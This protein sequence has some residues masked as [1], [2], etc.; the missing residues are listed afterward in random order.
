MQEEIIN[1]KNEAVAQIMSA[2][3]V[4]ELEN[5]KISYLGRNGKI[6]ALVQKLK[7]APIDERK[8]IGITLNQAKQN[9]YFSYNST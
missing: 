4:A 1:L 9:D 3:D 5:L 7:E 2:S 8:Q 6:N